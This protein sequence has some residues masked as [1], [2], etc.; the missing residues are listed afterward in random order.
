[1][2]SILL[3][4]A[5]R[6]RPIQSYYQVKHVRPS[7]KCQSTSAG[8]NEDETELMRVDESRDLDWLYLS[9]FQEKYFQCKD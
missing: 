6:V 1:M 5:I 8:L 2:K 3:Y 9:L 4:A 7:N